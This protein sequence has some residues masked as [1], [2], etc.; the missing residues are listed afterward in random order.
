M[1]AIEDGA[2]DE[3]AQIVKLTKDAR[4][5]AIAMDRTFS[6]SNAA[7]TWRA[8][9]N[10]L[11]SQA[12]ELTRLRE[13]NAELEK[14]IAWA[15]N[16]LFGSHEFFLSI[17]GGKDNEHHLDEGIE[18][19]KQHNRDYWSRIAELEG[20]IKH[21]TELGAVLSAA[22]LQNRARI[23]SLEATVREMREALT[24]L[25]ADVRDYERVNNLSP[26]PGRKDCWQSVT[27]ADT[28]LASSESVVKREGE[29]DGE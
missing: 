5:M 7:N 24:D 25:V 10:A 19:L 26:A 6:D 4:T 14:V 3:A 23:A 21:K 28:A 1:S 8:V 11:E 12:A 18:N 29:K 13:R 15:N 22:H 20:N 9:A 17:N 2:Q 16:S 27:R